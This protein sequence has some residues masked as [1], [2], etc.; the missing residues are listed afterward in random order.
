MTSKEFTEAGQA[1]Q[2]RLTGKTWGW[3]STLAFKIEMS[4][5]T[6]NRYANG[7]AEIPKRVALAVKLLTEQK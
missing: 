1:F 6:V 5:R 2:L 7:K 3:Q 4:V